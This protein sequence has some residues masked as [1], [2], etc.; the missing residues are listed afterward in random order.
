MNE[1]RYDVLKEELIETIGKMRRELLW[2]RIINSILI[3]VMAGIL[4]F[5]GIVVHKVYEFGKE[6]MEYAALI[7]EY[8]VGVEPMLKQLEQVDVEAIN[9]AISA[10]DVAAVNEAIEA[11]DVEAIN[12]AFAGVDA[13]SLGEIIGRLNNTMDALETS[14]EK[15]QDLMD[16]IKNFFRW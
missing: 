2:T 10:L 9:E 15:F 4:V 5:G 3:V 12:E 6:A 7:E 11:L 1:E 14:S 16:D 8:M 13:E